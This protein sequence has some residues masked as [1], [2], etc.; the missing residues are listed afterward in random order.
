M[1][2]ITLPMA[3]SVNSLWRSGKGR[4]F[5]SRRYVQWL[6]DAG[7]ELKAQRPKRFTGRVEIGIAIGRPDD[8]RKRDLDNFAAKAVLDLL[9]ELGV[10]EDDSLVTA[11][12]ARWDAAVAPGRIAVTIAAAN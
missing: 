2:T 11:L 7:W 3:P 1:T 8:Q 10:L 12:A 4:T 9:V 5:R 6:R